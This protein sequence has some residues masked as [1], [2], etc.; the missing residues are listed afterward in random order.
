MGV[1]SAGEGWLCPAHGG[2]R[3]VSRWELCYSMPLESVVVGRMWMREGCC[4]AR[5][6]GW[7]GW[8]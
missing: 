4:P 8:L 3:P 1:L 6:R 7:I 5:R 2:V